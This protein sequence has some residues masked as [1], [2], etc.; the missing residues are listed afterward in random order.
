[1]S[2]GKKS[3]LFSV[4]IICILI[5]SSLMAAC[6]QPAPAPSTTPTPAPTPKVE[7][8]TLKAI[9]YLASNSDFVSWLKKFADI[10]TQQ[11]NGALTIKY[12]GGP[13]VIPGPNQAQAVV[14]GAVDISMHDMTELVPEAALWDL[15]KLTFEQEKSSGFLDLMEAK[16][17]KAG[18]YYLWRLPVQDGFYLMTKFKVSKPEDFANKKMR[19][20]PPVA[21]FYKAL[22]IAGTS[23]PMPEQYAAL[24]RGVVQGKAGKLASTID[25]KSYEVLDYWV[26]HTFYS[27]G[28]EAICISLAKWNSLPADMQKL[29]VSVT[30]S[31]QEEA[32]KYY[33]AKIA[34]YKQVLKDNGMEPITFT[35]EDAK[36]F[37]DLAY[38]SEWAAQATKLEPEFINKAKACQ[39]LQ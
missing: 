33:A 25:E 36:H 16:Y 32:S 17:E 27:G 22:K 2:I 19:V 34:E 3:F 1:M 31:L 24:E 29:M 39:G 7:P 15:S 30:N 4:L 28:G 13:E 11:S 26:D 20:S 5:A 18:I 12:L 35:P 37:V 8:I 38:S 6:A 21:S 23:I 9:S 10:V 14:T